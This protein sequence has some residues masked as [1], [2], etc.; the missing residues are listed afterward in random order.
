MRGEDRRQ[1]IMD[2]LVE[3][4][5]VDID[6]LAE[7]FSVSKMTI[8]RDL[9]ELEQSGVLRK[10]R[11]G[12]TADAGNQFESDFRIRVQQDAEAKDRMARQALSLIEPGMTVMINDGSMSAVLGSM[13]PQRRPLTVITNNQAVI[14]DL[15]GEA[16]ITLLALGGIYSAKF[17][18]YSGVVTEE[19]LHRLRADIAFISAPAVSG[20]QAFHMDD[21]IVR[22]KQAMMLAGTRKCLLINHSRFNRTALHVLSDLKAFDWIITDDKPEAN[23]VEDLKGA[24]L[25]LTIAKA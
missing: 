9:D 14:S 8:H 3:H 18:A 2:L 17:N 23:V 1:L 4:R 22:A 24:G 6:D 5:S 7:R 20:L 19:S 12:A 25:N 10:V 21:N 16:G 13:L 11:G 15:L